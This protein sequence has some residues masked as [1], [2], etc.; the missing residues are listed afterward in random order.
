MFDKK[1]DIFSEAGR[2]E[3]RLDEAIVCK[4][5]SRTEECPLIL[6]VKKTLRPPGWREGESREVGV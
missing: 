4:E 6:S 1:R 3:G 5:E 2:N